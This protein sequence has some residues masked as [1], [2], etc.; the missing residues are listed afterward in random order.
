[1]R[2]SDWSS[3]VCSSDLARRLENFAGDEFGHGAVVERLGGP[4]FL[5]VPARPLS[6]ATLHAQERALHVALAEP[7]VGDPSGRL[8][9]RIATALITRDEAVAEQLHEVGRA[10]G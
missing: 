1:M 5:I 3:D 2:I 6:M 8:A 10:H 7:M 9:I 4:R